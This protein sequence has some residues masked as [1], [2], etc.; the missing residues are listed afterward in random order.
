M[1]IQ[2]QMVLLA[3]VLSVSDREAIMMQVQ[4]RNYQLGCVRHFEALHPN[5]CA[6]GVSMDGVGNHPNAWMQASIA[7]YQIKESKTTTTTTTTDSGGAVSNAIISP[8]SD[9]HGNTTP[10]VCAGEV[11]PTHQ[12]ECA[13]KVEAVTPVT[14][15]NTNECKYE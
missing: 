3:G 14:S 1:Q 11:T 5:A 4:T 12:S 7:Y 15:N 9:A 10:S 2:M 6:M 8:S 13:T